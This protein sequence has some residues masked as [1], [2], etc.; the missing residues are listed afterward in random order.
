M[1]RR[2]PNPVFGAAQI[3]AIR[4][5]VAV[6][7]GAQDFVASMGTALVDALGVT[8]LLLPGIGHFDLPA[9]AAFRD[10]AIRFLG[11]AHEHKD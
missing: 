1:L 3:A 5:P 9:Q 8:Q 4:A 2:P 6:V 7:N 11:E 10:T